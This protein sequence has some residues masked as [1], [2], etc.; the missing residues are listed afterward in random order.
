[1]LEISTSSKLFH[2]VTINFIA[3]LETIKKLEADKVKLSE[4]WIKL[5]Q[6]NNNEDKLRQKIK[7]RCSESLICPPSEL[8]T[9]NTAKE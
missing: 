8:E 2:F 3:L 4:K 1:M 9:S 5:S 6:K 7:G